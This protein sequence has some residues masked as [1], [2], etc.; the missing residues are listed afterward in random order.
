MC[1]RLWKKLLPPLLS[2][3]PP[4]LCSRL[5]KTCLAS[6]RRTFHLDPARRLL[7]V[8]TRRLSA[9]APRPFRSS[10]ELSV[11]FFSAEHAGRK[12]SP[13]TARESAASPTSG[14]PGA[15]HRAPFPAAGPCSGPD[16]ARVSVGPF[17]TLHVFWAL[18]FCQARPCGPSPRIPAGSAPGCHRACCARATVYG[19][20]GSGGLNR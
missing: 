9:W 15:P 14:A 6:A 13:R 18:L 2:R 1:S 5:I 3:L 11:L 17:D 19:V 8:W 7:L 12:L 4:A 20:R 16:R 10:G